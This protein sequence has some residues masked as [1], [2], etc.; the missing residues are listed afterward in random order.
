M[1]ALV[2]GD[3]DKLNSLKYTTIYDYFALLN[4]KAREHQKQARQNKDFV[5]NNQN[6]F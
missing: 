2:D 3:A 4:Y 1:M 5:R 6:R